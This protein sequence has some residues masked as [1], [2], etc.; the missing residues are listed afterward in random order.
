MLDELDQVQASKPPHLPDQSP[1]S[2][3]HHLA[4]C[5]SDL[6]GVEIQSGEYMVSCR[7]FPVSSVFPHHNVN[8]RPLAC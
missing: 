2:S 1:Q 7:R 6:E 8:A 3:R 5:F 4:V